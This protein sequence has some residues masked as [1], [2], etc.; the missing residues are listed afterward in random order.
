MLGI[1]LKQHIAKTTLSGQN[2]LGAQ[3]S[4]SPEHPATSFSH[5]DSPQ[6][7]SSTDNM[8]SNVFVQSLTASMQK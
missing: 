2:V 4:H 8:H 1:C 7:T 5:C 3:G 6:L